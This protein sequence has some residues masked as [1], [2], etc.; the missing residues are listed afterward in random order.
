MAPLAHCVAL[1]AVLASG[2]V[3]GGGP[4]VGYGAKRGLI[5]GVEAAAGIPIAQLAVGIQNADRFRIFHVDVTGNS[6]VYKDE[7]DFGAGGRFGVGY[8][9][10]ST[11]GGGGVFAMGAQTSATTS[12]AGAAR[13][14][15]AP[16]SSGLSC[17]LRAANGSWL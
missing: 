17:A 2:C 10:G 12:S 11:H 15:A 16:S 9:G 6:A 7:H 3:A 13:T 4:Y 8:G 14:R 5:Y 1:T